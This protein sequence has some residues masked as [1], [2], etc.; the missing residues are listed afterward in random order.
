M[1]APHAPDDFAGPL[2]DVFGDRRHAAA[3][4]RLLVSPDAAL[5]VPPAVE[6]A[7]WDRAGAHDRAS[8]AG[9]LSRARAD[10]AEPWPQPLA[11]DAARVHRDGDRATWEKAAFARQHRLTRLAVAAAL[12]GEAAWIDEVADGVQLLCE[13]SSWCWPAHDDT[14]SRHGAVLATVTDPYLDLGAGEV[15][16]QLAWLDQLLGTPLDEHYPGLRTRIRHEVRTRII[17]PFVNRRDWHW[18]GL[19]GHVHNWNPWIH[20]NVLVTALRLLDGADDGMLRAEVIALVIAGLDRYVAALPA[21]G[22]VD[23]GYSY[24]WAGAA[25]ALEALDLLAHATDG[26]LDA[27]PAVPALR[28]TV[29]FPHRCQLG[30]GWVVDIADGQARPSEPQPWD[31]L[32]RAARRVGDSEAE[33][34]A[35]AHRDV[36][37]SEALGLGRTLRALT[38]GAWLAASPTPSPLPRDVWL[39]STQVLLTRENGGSPFGLTLVAKGGHNDENHNHNDVGELIVCSD[40]V[41]VLVDAGRPTYTATTFGSDRYDIWTMQ[42]TWHNVPQVAG[43][44]QAAGAAFA[45]RDVAVRI[46]D[47]AGALSLELVGAYPQPALLSWR[48]SMTL[49]RAARRVVVDDAWELADDAPAGTMIRMLVAGAVRLSSGVAHITPLAGA[50]PVAVRWEGGIPARLI[51]RPLEDPML[52]EVWGE[53][54]T[55]IELDVGDR[56]AVSVAVERDKTS[57]GEG[58]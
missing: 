26:A 46:D 13:Q 14:F 17:A 34:F 8:A 29:A 53:A 48:R 22:A 19:D 7:V 16:A 40:G 55:M 25:R 36:R 20:A 3:L 33:A 57:E 51:E 32:F 24:W 50:S 27:L 31:T 15:A 47:A 30:D 42:S 4:A 21:D 45:A 2:A 35:R 11:H 43:T 9:L 54:L 56:R 39:P 44:A 41:P 6:R 49:D 12:T 10:L 1:S 58:R 23:E 18:I 52:S 38:D 5:P 28:E 37:V